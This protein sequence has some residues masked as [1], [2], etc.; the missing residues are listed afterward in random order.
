M[1]PA[2]RQLALHPVRALQLAWKAVSDLYQ[3]DGFYRLAASYGAGSS[4][5]TGKSIS[6]ETALE[7]SVVWACTRVISESVATMPLHLMRKRG[8]SKL[9]ATDHPL[10]EILHDQPNLDMTALEFREALT[11]H[12]VHWGR[13]YAKI[14]RRT[15]GNEVIGMMPIHPQDVTRSE[16]SVSDGRIYFVQENGKEIKYPAREIFTFGGMSK[17]GIDSFPVWHMARQS[18][19]LALILEEWEAR[20]FRTG[21]KGAGIVVKK[22]P[23]KH[24]DDRKRWREEWND[25]YGSSENFH[26]NVLLEGE[27]DYKQISTD[28]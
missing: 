15:G 16:P 2:I 24:D 13:C 19:S 22:L 28:P 12:A 21:G 11:L 10:Y 5:H 23:F 8:D 25:V 6:A 17:N 4:T 1:K 20:L 9:P 3:R 26:K 27:W 7:C 18:V 14:V